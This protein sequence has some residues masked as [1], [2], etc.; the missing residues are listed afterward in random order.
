MNLSGLSFAA[1]F[2]SL[3]KGGMQ[4]PQMLIATQLELSKAS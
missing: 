3:V 4:E 1:A 2:N